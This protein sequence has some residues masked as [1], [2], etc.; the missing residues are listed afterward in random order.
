MRRPRTPRQ[1]EGTVFSTLARL[2]VVVGTISALVVAATV[3]AVCAA[4]ADTGRAL[5]RA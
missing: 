5:L 1:D 2:L 4:R 3:A